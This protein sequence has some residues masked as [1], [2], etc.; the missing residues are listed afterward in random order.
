MADAYNFIGIHLTMTGHFE[1]A[2]E[3]FDATLELEP[4]HQYVYLN[5]GIALYY[6]G[7]DK[8]AVEDLVA[9]HQLDVT[10]PYRVIWRYIAEQRVDKA[11]A[12]KNLRQNQQTLA[13]SNWAKQIGELF[14]MNLSQAQFVEEMTQGV[15]TPK[16]M[17][18]RLCEAYFYLGIFAGIHQQPERAL[19]Y[20]K[21]SLAT[22]VFEFVEHRYA[23]REIIETRFIIHQQSLV[24]PESELNH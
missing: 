2:Y 23:R 22:N 10:D 11:Q 18:E 17:A 20:F 24:Q 3:A 21:L 15:E 13:D 5:R 6:G 4:E 16:Q 9:F 7:H 8:L 12:L 14:L 19:N 1:K